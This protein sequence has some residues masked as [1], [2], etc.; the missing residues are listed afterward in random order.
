MS[1]DPNNVYV[2]L[3]TDVTRGRI[4]GA[5]IT[6]PSSAGAVFIALLAVFVHVAGIHLWHLVRFALH[7]FQ[8]TDKGL[9]PLARQVQAVLR[10]NGSAASTGLRLLELL[11]HWRGRS[12]PLGAASGLGVAGLA[13]AACIALAGVSSSTILDTTNVVVLLSSP[14]CGKFDK[15]GLDAEEI[16]LNSA[17]LVAYLSYEQEHTSLSSTYARQCYNGTSPP[18]ACNGFAVPNITWSTDYHASCPFSEQM[19]IGAAMAE[20]T[21]R[22]NSNAVFGLNFPVDQQ[23]DFRR[24]LTCVPI[25][26][27]GF[28]STLPYTLTTGSNSSAAGLVVEN[29]TANISYYSYGPA[30][31]G[32]NFTILLDSYI[33]G[34]L[35]GYY[36]RYCLDIPTLTTA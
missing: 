7:Q 8:A 33:A 17:K 32:S 2:G 18:E 14:H 23:V 3:W 19:C 36:L 11:W 9:H 12:A 34:E 21:G 25:A 28:V 10:N 1:V 29:R 24:L 30:V 22:L 27:D 4:L 6:L 13:F 26:Q 20:D 5:V 16:V 31:D 15:R 35:S